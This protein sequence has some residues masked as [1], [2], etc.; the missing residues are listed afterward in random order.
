MAKWMDEKFVANLSDKIK[1]GITDG[2][3]ELGKKYQKLKIK[4]LPDFIGEVYGYYPKAS[5]S[6]TLI[7]GMLDPMIGFT[8]ENA[9]NLTGD[10]K[11]E[12]EK[13][14]FDRIKITSS[15]PEDV[16]LTGL[17]SIGY[18][19]LCVSNFRKGA[20]AYDVDGITEEKKEETV[21]TAEAP[22]L[23]ES[24]EAAVKEATTK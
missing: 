13:K 18:T 21:E 3:S 10:E 23:G 22:K 16:K 1:T 15:L 24:I 14:Y 17:M 9:V 4:D 12:Y 5:K 8:Y 2:L 6:D 20:D 7:I 19:P 11:K